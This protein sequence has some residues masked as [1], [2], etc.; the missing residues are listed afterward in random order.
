[1][2]IADHVLELYLKYFEDPSDVSTFIT[3]LLEQYDQ[4]DLLK[5]LNKA[6]KDELEEILRL[7]L[8]PHLMKE[9]S[10]SI[11]KKHSAAN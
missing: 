10:Q 2:K 3:L 5:M 11:S 8:I 6:P 7:Y 9:V 1:M 4:E